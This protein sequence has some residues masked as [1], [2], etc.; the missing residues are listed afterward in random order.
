MLKRIWPFRS[1][2]EEEEEAPRPRRSRKAEEEV[3]APSGVIKRDLQVGLA[4]LT[5][6]CLLIIPRL[7]TTVA[8]VGITR[9]RMK[10]GLQSPTTFVNAVERTD[11]KLGSSLTPPAPLAN[12]P[13]TVKTKFDADALTQR[14]FDTA[15]GRDVDRTR[16]DRQTSLI[17]RPN[18]RWTK[19]QTAWE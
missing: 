17:H 14:G 9:A 4:L 12:K 16:Q 15:I 19:S 3:E 11:S 8:K 13:A 7:P 5:M 18:K 2:E 1:E 10:S 6:V